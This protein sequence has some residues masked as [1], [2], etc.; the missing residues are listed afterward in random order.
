M[1]TILLI[2]D[3]EL[4][5]ESISELL[6][7]NGYNVI[8]ANNGKNGI[9]KALFHNPDLILIDVMMPIMD[10]HETV[11]ILRKN[12]SFNFTPIIFMSAKVKL[13]DQRHGINLGAEDYFT[14]PISAKNLLDGVRSKLDKFKKIKEANKHSSGLSAHNVYFKAMH[15]VNTALSG[16]LGSASILEDFLPDLED[17]KKLELISHIKESAMRI[18]RMYENNNWL[19]KI[20]RNKIPLDAKYKQEISIN[21]TLEYVINE[22][23][24]S[25]EKNNITIEANMESKKV[26][27]VE[28]ILKK[29]FYELLSNSIKFSKPNTEIKITGSL[30]SNSYVITIEDESTG[31]AQ[32]PAVNQL[33]FKQYKREVY[34]QQGLGIGLFI[35]LHLLNILKIK[36]KTEQITS[37]NSGTIS[38]L[39]LPL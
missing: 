4:I 9:L 19:E 22:L 15:E 34:E 38:K 37:G 26:F 39:I 31:F 18:K 8:T 35:A 13:E 29:I 3:E 27:I 14:K 33:F 32:L 36:Y 25:L 20:T 2:D 5:C 10:G 1:E 12:P 28:D 24:P 11:G 16:I 7:I 21:Q 17:S 30:E 6:S 23:K